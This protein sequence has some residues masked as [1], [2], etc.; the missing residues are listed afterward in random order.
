[1]EIQPKVDLVTTEP[2]PLAVETAEGHAGQ[3]HEP[4][5]LLALDGIRGLA[6]LL[7]LQFHWAEGLTRMNPVE[8]TSY[9][10]LRA[11]WL[12]VDLFFVLSGF[13]ITGILSDSKNGFHY[14]R[15]FY[16]RRVLRI[17]PAYYGFLIVAEFVVPGL[18]RLAHHKPIWQTSGYGWYW[19]YI[20]NIGAALGHQDAEGFGH[21]WSLAVEEQFYFFWPLLVY[22][23]SRR[24]AKRA[25][26][27]CIFAALTLRTCMVLIGHSHPAAAVLMPCRL[28]ALAI[29]AW[30][31]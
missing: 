26:V 11:G 16:M 15:N 31:A 28:D 22:F 12:G 1:M 14:F 2:T 18:L 9:F 19:L 17:F 21:F 24:A 4:R 29:G 23:L 10:L 25:S 6:V 8:S 3:V 20:S 5:R 27:A 30:L 13:L 7:V